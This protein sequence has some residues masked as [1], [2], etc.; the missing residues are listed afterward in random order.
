MDKREK[1]EGVEID[2]KRLLVVLWRRLWIIVLVGAVLGGAAFSYAW[3]GIVPTYSASVQLYVNNNYVGSPGFSSSQITAAQD[4]ADTYMV[5]LES[6]SVLEDVAQMAGVNYSYGQLKAMVASSAVNDTEVFKVVVT[7]TNYKHAALIANA[8]ADILPEKISSVVEGSSVRVVDYAV[9]NPNPV[10]PDYERYAF[11]GAAAGAL[12]TAAIF[13]IAEL[14]N[15]TI[16]SEEYLAQTYGEYPLLAVIP[17]VQSQKT[18]YYKG[19]YES[20]EKRR[21]AK[22]SGGAKNV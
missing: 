13:V 3:F 20:A 7:S 9:E 14:M 11:Y 15:T 12:A 10:G 1:R 4:L 21:P 19:Y 17:G 22:K 16:T 5:I 6:R 18:G 2:L 8:I